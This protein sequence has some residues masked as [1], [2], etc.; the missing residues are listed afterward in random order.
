MV[1]EEMAQEL[2]Y[3]KVEGTNVILAVGVSDIDKM[4]TKYKGYTLTECK[5]PEGVEVRF[6]E[7]CIGDPKMF[8]VPYKHFYDDTYQNVKTVYWEGPCCIRCKNRYKGDSD[9]CFKHHTDTNCYRFKL[10]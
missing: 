10:E 1:K 8:K 2:K 3:Y 7:P 4:L 9:F 6:E 5:K